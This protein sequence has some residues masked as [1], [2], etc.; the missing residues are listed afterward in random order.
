MMTMNIENSRLK[1]SLRKKCAGDAYEA[2]KLIE[3][4]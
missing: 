3:A 4:H 2:H 1:E